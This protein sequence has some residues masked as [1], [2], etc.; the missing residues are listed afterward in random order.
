MK[1]FSFLVYWNN[2]SST[3]ECHGQKISY[4]RLLQYVIIIYTWNW[5]SSTKPNWNSGYWLIKYYTIH[6]STKTYLFCFTKSKCIKRFSSNGAQ[7]QRKGS[8]YILEP[9]LYLLCYSTQLRKAKSS[10]LIPSY[11]YSKISIHYTKNCEFINKILFKMLRIKI[12]RNNVLSCFVQNSSY[13]LIYI[14]SVRKCLTI[15]LSLLRYIVTIEKLFV[16]KSCIFVN[17]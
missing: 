4:L 16:R 7:W 12:S 10:S 2:T 14:T 17:D 15:L 3:F 9:L 5:N 6:N 13:T 8:W 1:I 11:K